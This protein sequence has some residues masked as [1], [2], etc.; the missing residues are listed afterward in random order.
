MAEFSARLP[1]LS[2]ILSDQ[3]TKM[4]TQ[5]TTQ[6]SE[7]PASPAT[8]QGGDPSL[9]YKQKGIEAGQ[10]IAVAEG[11]AQETWRNV[12]MEAALLLT[13]VM[14]FSLEEWLSGFAESLR[15]RFNADSLKVRKSEVKAIILAFRVKEFTQIVGFNDKKEPIKVSKSGREWMSDKEGFGSFSKWASLARKIND[16]AKGATSKPVQKS[17]GPTKITDKGIKRVEA[18]VKVLTGDQADKL[19]GTVAS[20]VTE[21]KA[22]EVVQEVIK[23]VSANDMPKIMRDVAAMTTVKDSED[24][25]PIL[26]HKV[27]RMEENGWENR[28]IVRME[29]QCATLVESKDASV[30]NLA[31][32]ISELCGNWLAEQAALRAEALKAKEQEQQPEQPAQPQVAAG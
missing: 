22:G 9:N 17:T 12:I 20:K 29:N 16:Y 28:L 2:G 30:V 31:N 15:D 8:V 11:A 10:T 21:A 32:A 1:D 6:Q 5:N 26:E 19:A 4:T 24:L 25:L 14:D 23:R 27:I 18:E 3:G 13:S 7:Q